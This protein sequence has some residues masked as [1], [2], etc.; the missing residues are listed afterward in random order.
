VWANFGVGTLKTPWRKPPS[1]REVGLGRVNRDEFAGQSGLARKPWRMQNRI[2]KMGPRV[3]QV[4]GL[5]GI[6]LLTRGW[7]QASPVTFVFTSDVHYG[8]ARSS[9]RGAAQVEAA[10]VNA[11]LVRKINR[12][13]EVMMPKDEGLRAGQAVGL[14]DFVVVTGDITNRQE[15]YPLPIQ[16]SAV[17]WQQFSSGFLDAVALRAPNG[18]RTPILVVPGNH[19]IS[20]AIGSPN[21][22]RPETDATAMAEIY[23]RNMQPAV[24]RTKDTYRFASDKVYYSKDFGG[25]H[26]VFLTIWPD[27]QARAWMEQDFR[28][29]AATTP[30]FIF[31]HDQP[32]I[33]AKHL[34]NP[35]GKR[36]INSR[37]K[38]ENLVVDVCAGGSTVEANTIV[39]QRALAAFLR[40]HRN[41]A[42]YFHGNANWQEFYSWKG[43]DG[44]LALPV[45][46][47][48]SPIK[49]KDS[50]KDE[51]KL[52]FQ[53]VTYDLAV[54]R[55]TA[56]E[57]RWNALG[58]ED[59]D[60]TP[61]DWA[62]VRTINLR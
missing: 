55:L 33:E 12:L 18:S 61:V 36:D 24:P 22:L 19:D 46:R 39:E 47:V 38:F 59:R 43:P 7:L 32:D 13:P 23:N 6:T 21:R 45:F 58:R 41:V 14:V 9:F 34:T 2:T 40:A 16:S 20:N 31:C 42:A 44:D 57:C 52:S 8:I 11:A 49:G 30:I 26:L 50:G 48:D 1:F 25:V 17:S 27:S 60:A 53:V 15:L 29:V 10:I 5:L 37:D 3:W 54:K 4:I 28:A 56:R 62:A 51:T 35:N